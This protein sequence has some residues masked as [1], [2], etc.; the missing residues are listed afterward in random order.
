VAAV[1]LIRAILELVSENF[2]SH[3]LHPRVRERGW[4]DAEDIA[5]LVVTSFNSCL[6][7]TIEASVLIFLL[8]GHVYVWKALL[9]RVALITGI[10]AS[11]FT[12]IQVRPSDSYEKTCETK[13]CAFR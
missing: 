11:L 2:G 1:N 9:R 7:W 10:L 3:G 6:V 12:I 8:H 5:F 4:P 13:S